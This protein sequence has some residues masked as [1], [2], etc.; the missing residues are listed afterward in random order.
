MQRHT[1]LA[2]L[3]EWWS[4]I[5]IDEEDGFEATTIQFELGDPNAANGYSSR[6]PGNKHSI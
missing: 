6:V 1:L 5:E 2:V 3:S 4:Q